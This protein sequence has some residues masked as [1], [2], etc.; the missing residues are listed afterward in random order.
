MERK[1]TWRMRLFQDVI[2]AF[3]DCVYEFDNTW[4]NYDESD[5]QYLLEDQQY[6][7]KIG[8]PSSPDIKQELSEY[9]KECASYIGNALSNIEENKFRRILI[10][11][12][13]VCN[14]TDGVASDV[15]KKCFDTYELQIKPKVDT[16]LSEFTSSSSTD[17]FNSLFAPGHI[18]S[19]ALKEYFTMLSP[20]QSFS[21]RCLKSEPIYNPMVSII[22]KGIDK[23]M[24]NKQYDAAITF[25][26]SL[27]TFEAVTECTKLVSIFNKE[28]TNIAKVRQYEGIN[29]FLDDW[30][31]LLIGYNRD[32]ANTSYTLLSFLQSRIPSIKKDIPILPISLNLQACQKSNKLGDVFFF[33]VRSFAIQVAND[34][35]DYDRALI[36]LNLLDS[37]YSTASW[38]HHTIMSDKNTLN[39]NIINK[40]HQKKS[41]RND[42]IMAFF[43]IPGIPILIVVGIIWLIGT[44]GGAF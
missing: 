29:S 4:N 22:I 19:D 43:S 24:D 42:L 8:I 21:E 38:C 9:L 17:N 3:C 30:I 16:I 41:E 40:E 27:L 1:L 14:F 12:L 6:T 34:E 10:E 31:N 20:L 28:R 39:Q 37:C 44:I 15:V 25:V 23:L 35:Q 5:V 26:N 18:A 11:I 36:V 32:N 13:D 33:S 7:N 2:N